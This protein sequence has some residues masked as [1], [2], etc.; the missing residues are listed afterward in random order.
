MT[1]Q[2]IE[3]T[4]ELRLDNGPLNLVDQTL[5][6]SL[7]K[8]LTH[9]EK[10]SGVRAL[11]LHGGSGR[12]FCAGSDM[13]TFAGLGDSAAERKILFEDWVL[14]R[15]AALPFP[16]IAAVDGP[17]LGGGLELALACDLRV[18]RAGVSLGLTESRIGGLA[19]NGALR[20]TR[21]IG[22]GRA[23]EMLF[24]G[25]TI[26]VDK[27][28][29]W[30]LVNRLAA[31]SALQEA[32]ELAAAI[33][34]RG[35]LSNRLAKELVESALDSPLGAGL[36][37]ATVLQQRIFD[38]ADLSAGVASFFDKRNAEFTGA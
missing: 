25:E 32:R 34:G 11:V 28:L 29:E 3:A 36:A 35:P 17:A 6:H 23:K 7:D 33:G 8:A 27:A 21:L 10:Q 19:G 15:L 20:L 26:S 31:E 24:T 12:A 22:P 13:R 2:I 14:R 30:G 38:S 9:V 1:V 16:T 18:V 37:K 4:A 5:L